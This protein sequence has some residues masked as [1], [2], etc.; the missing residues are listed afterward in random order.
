MKCKYDL[1]MN[2]LK[3]HHYLCVVV[4]DELNE[5]EVD[6]AAEGRR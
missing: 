5:G 1:K 4:A 2:Q 3:V 6:E